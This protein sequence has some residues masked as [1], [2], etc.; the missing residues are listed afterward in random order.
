MLDENQKHYY[1]IIK[2][3][4]DLMTGTISE[5]LKE[6]IVKEKKDPENKEKEK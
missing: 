1:L 5:L 3:D 6:G 2:D 4:D